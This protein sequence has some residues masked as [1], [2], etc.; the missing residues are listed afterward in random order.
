MVH[1]IY[2]RLHHLTDKHNDGS[3]V[4]LATNFSQVCK[5]EKSNISHYTPTPHKYVMLDQNGTNNH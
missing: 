1:P 4:Q 2:Q 5:V 3:V